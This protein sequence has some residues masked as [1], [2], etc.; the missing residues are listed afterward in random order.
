[1]SCGR[2]AP[3]SLL[4]RLHRGQ[5]LVSEVVSEALG[6]EEFVVGVGPIR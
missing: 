6:G 4:G 3:G 2:P 1:M 5:V